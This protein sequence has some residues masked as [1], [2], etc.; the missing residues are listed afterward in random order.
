MLHKHTYTH[1]IYSHICI[2]Q[3]PIHGIYDLLCLS[4][5]KWACTTVPYT[6]NIYILYNII[7]NMNNEYIRY[8]CLIFSVLILFTYSCSR[9]IMYNTHII[10]YYLHCPTIKYIQYYRYNCNIIVYITT[11]GPNG[12]I[13][14]KITFGSG[15]I[16][17]L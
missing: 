17:Y 12:D 2:Y 8:I 14:G 3:I 15:K 7:H 6:C 11:H 9:V 4:Q 16:P 5:S 1:K 13:L 10:S